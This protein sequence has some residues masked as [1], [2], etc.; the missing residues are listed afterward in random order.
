MG[1]SLGIVIH[2]SFTLTFS[3]FASIVAC[4]ENKQLTTRSFLNLT[5]VSVRRLNVKERVLLEVAFLV[6]AYAS[7]FEIFFFFFCSRAWMESNQ[8]MRC[9]GR[10][11]RE[12]MLMNKLY[13]GV[14][15]CSLT[16]WAY[17]KCKQKYSV[18]LSPKM[19][20]FSLL[21]RSFTAEHL[22]IFYK[23]QPPHPH[24]IHTL[25]STKLACYIFMKTFHQKGK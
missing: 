14:F 6:L 4:F 15:P 25:S 18:I 19:F 12:I 20:Y 22:G 21:I 7:Y 23:K 10:F 3:V 17:S 1:A 16:I 11:S 2:A 8:Q 13:F 24:P 9:W 5:P